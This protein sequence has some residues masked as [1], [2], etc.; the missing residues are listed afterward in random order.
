MIRFSAVFARKHN[1]P[2]GY[3]VI[4][5]FGDPRLVRERYASILSPEGADFRKD[6]AEVR[7]VIENNLA[8][9]H[10]FPDPAKLE[11]ERLAAELARAK[12]IREAA[13]AAKAAAE[14]A[15]IAARTAAE[16]L[17]E[18]TPEQRALLEQHDAKAAAPRAADDK[19]AAEQSAASAADKAR[20]AAEAKRQQ[21]AATVSTDAAA[22]SLA[23]ALQPPP[24]LDFDPK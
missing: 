9:E 18:L 2:E 7:L 1:A 15:R 24:K 4:A 5:S 12:A 8:G 13:E 17:K 23:A 16:S 22:K 11:Q 10:T 19:R 20:V 3:A 21:D 6:H 14:K